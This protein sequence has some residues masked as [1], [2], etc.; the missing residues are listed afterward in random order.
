[1]EEAD[2]TL[3]KLANAR[4]RADK[5]RAQWEEEQSEIRGMVIRLY[6]TSS[7]S[8][9]KIADGSGY[10]RSHINWLLAGLRSH[11]PKRQRPRAS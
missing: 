11:H 9:Q 6:L 2:L 3:A 10:S 1:M 8:R 7:F 5:L 4:I